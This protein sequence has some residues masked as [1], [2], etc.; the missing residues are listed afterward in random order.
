MKKSEMVKK[1]GDWGDAQQKAGIEAPDS[2]EEF[3][4]L[5]IDKLV[6]FGMFPPYNSTSGDDSVLEWEPEDG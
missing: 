4:T 5:L 6:E 1:L 3:L 2:E